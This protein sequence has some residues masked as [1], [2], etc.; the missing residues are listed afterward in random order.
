MTWCC[1]YG[2]VTYGPALAE[3][4]Q[5]ARRAGSSS[6]LAGTLTP[7]AHRS[8]R[9]PWLSACFVTPRTP[10][11]Q[12]TLGLAEKWLSGLL[13]HES[14]CACGLCEPARRVRPFGVYRVASAWA[15]GSAEEGV[16]SA[17]FA[18]RPTPGQ[19]FRT[20][21]ENRPPYLSATVGTVH[22]Q[23]STYSRRVL[24]DMAGT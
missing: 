19:R 18:V 24:Y 17:F 10:A 2:A 16:I 13:S 14:D 11:N 1:E 4:V 15:G 22:A 20:A 3:G 8:P 5:S 6:R 9:T 12:S 7:C 21:V 23:P